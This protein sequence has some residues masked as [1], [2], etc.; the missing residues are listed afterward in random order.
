MQPAHVDMWQT[1]SNPLIYL[2]IQN[3]SSSH[4][5]C[6]TVQHIPQANLIANEQGT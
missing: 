1:M 5:F 4:C 6:I 3:C 2:A